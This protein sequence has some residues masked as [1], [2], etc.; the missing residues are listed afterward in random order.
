MSDV[1]APVGRLRT[2]INLGNPN[3]ARL[4]SAGQPAGASVAP[5][6]QCDGQ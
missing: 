3:L 4:D 6:A 2:E 1:L 5:A